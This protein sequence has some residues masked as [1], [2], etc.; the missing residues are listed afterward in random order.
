MGLI[1]S[2]FTYSKENQTRV[3]DITFG[4]RYEKCPTKT[5]MNVHTKKKVAKQLEDDLG[6]LG[7]F[8]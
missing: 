3:R 6:A 8:Q 1:F 7:L 4:T 2:Q 5:I